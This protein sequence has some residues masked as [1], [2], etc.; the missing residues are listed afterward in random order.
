M[1]EI[2]G[3]ITFCRMFTSLVGFRLDALCVCNVNDLSFHPPKILKFSHLWSLPSAGR[4]DKSCGA[5]I[6]VVVP[7]GKCHTSEQACALPFPI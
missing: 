4:V 6:R 5:S 7:Y 1:S 3:L 2:E